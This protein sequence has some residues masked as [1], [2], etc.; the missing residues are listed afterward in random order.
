MS[1]QMKEEV[2]ES[3]VKRVSPELIN[4]VKGEF[5]EDPLQT[6]SNRL[7]N[8]AIGLDVMLEASLTLNAHAIGT[9]LPV[10]KDTFFKYTKDLGGLIRENNTTAA[11]QRLNDLVQSFIS[12]KKVTESLF[13]R[14]TQIIENFPK[15]SAELSDVSADIQKIRHEL[16]EENVVIIG[17]DELGK[18][19]IELYKLLV[20]AQK[21][22]E[23]AIEEAEESVE[24]H[25][26]KKKTVKDKL[27]PGGGSDA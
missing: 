16:L 14:L 4:R 11:G 1:S 12:Y 9:E 5:A 20:S 7:D 10:I 8:M 3:F 18:L 24:E 27:K 19:A 23:D 15:Y 25:M 6:S 22:E 13:A 26:A 2:D 17:E 21:G